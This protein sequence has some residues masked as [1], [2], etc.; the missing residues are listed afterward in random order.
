[1]LSRNPRNLLLVI[2]LLFSV[3]FVINAMST[4]S[5]ITYELTCT[6]VNKTS[7]GTQT[8][9]FDRDTT[10]SGSETLV[11]HITDGDGTVIFSSVDTQPVGSM[12]VAVSF[13]YTSSPN[14][15]PIRMR[16][17][18]PAGNGMP[19]QVLQDITGNCAS[20][21]TFV[22]DPDEPTAVDPIVARPPDSRVNW[23][24]GDSNVGILYPTANGSL[25]LYEYESDT[26]YNDFITQADI[27]A[28]L[29]NPA[30]TSVLVKSIGRVS[31]YVL[32]SGGIQINFGPDAEGKIWSFMM[33]DLNDRENDG[34]YL[35]DPNL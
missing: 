29:A 21:T 3:P 11:Y 23:Q 16:I 4:S 17:F 6:G 14:F 30:E 8:Y 27:D 26:Y 31:V 7:G 12:P 10:G 22:P 32:P 2:I 34:S 13:N 15:N 19:E 25:D 18:S 33:T 28:F 35:L 9:N 5:P 1:M 24:Y 20:L